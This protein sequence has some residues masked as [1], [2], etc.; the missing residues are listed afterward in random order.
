MVE[1]KS[2]ASGI[3]CE[4][5]ETTSGHGYYRIFT[6]RSKPYLRRFWITLTLISVVCFIFHVTLLGQQYTSFRVSS[7][8]AMVS[9]KGIFPEVTVCN[10]F[11]MDTK[12]WNDPHQNPIVKYKNELNG[13]RMK[14]VLSKVHKFIWYQV[15]GI[16]G[17]YANIPS[18]ELRSLGHEKS[19]LI[20]QCTLGQ[21]RQWYTTVCS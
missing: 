1:T 9:G 11:P 14:T 20:K 8:R 4:F 18:E 12:K 16:S 2:S 19:N 7:N 21:I 15:L 10:I 13:L 5:C 3:L 17:W 6:S